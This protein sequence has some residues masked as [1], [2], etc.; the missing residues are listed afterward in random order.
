MT[1]AYEAG[2]SDPCL[3][4]TALLGRMGQYPPK[5]STTGQIRRTTFTLVCTELGRDGQPHAAY[6]SCECWGREAEQAA[7][8]RPGA[9]VLFEG[10][11][12]PRRGEDG[13]R[14]LVSGARLQP[15]VFDEEAA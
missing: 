1:T 8:L 14:L 9:W 11:V 13:W 5:T 4:Y 3:N 2:Y 12:T 10:A 7:S 15:L 6:V